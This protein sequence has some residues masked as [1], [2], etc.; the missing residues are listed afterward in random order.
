MV[1]LLYIVYITLYITLF[2]S[3]NLGYAFTQ[4]N[5]SLHVAL[6]KYDM[7]FS[8]VARILLARIRRYVH[9]MKPM[10]YYAGSGFCLHF[11]CFNN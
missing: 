7:T 3:L 4:Q 1:I 6:I 11:L 5:V 2:Y 8:C 9:P 10:L